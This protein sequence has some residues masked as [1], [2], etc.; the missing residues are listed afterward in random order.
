MPNFKIRR[1]R[2]EPVPPPQ[3]AP[4]KEEKID[5]TEMEEE[6]VSS[7]T[8]IAEAMDRMGFDKQPRN[9][10]VPQKV[11]KVG[12]KKAPPPQQ[13]PI[14]TRPVQNLAPKRQ[15]YRSLHHITDPYRRNPTM[16]YAKPPRK[17][18]RGVAKL[19]YN[20]HYGLGGEHLD[21]RTKSTLLYHHCF[22]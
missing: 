5:D 2:R 16:Q 4:V 20:S 9:V 22:G 6:A 15:D 21:T 8:E 7:D 12:F 13:R 18:S 14:V 19:R 1:K 3:P 17:N 10:P 11:R